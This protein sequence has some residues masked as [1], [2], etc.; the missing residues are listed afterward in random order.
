MKSLGVVRFAAGL[1]ILFASVR[2]LMAQIIVSV[3]EFGHGFVN[4]NPIPVQS[5]GSLG[6]Q[7]TL[8]YVVMPGT[9]TIHEG[10]LSGPISDL[11]LFTNTFLFF[12]SSS[13]G[14]VDSLADVASFIT[15]AG[16]TADIVEQGSGG[17]SFALYTP[18]SGQPGFNT[19]SSLG[20]NY[21][22]I[23]D[24]PEPSA[25]LL[26]MLGGG[27]LLVRRARRAKAIPSYGA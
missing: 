7:Y 6:L 2:V 13:S 9:V 3:D 12:E 11:I 21:T 24:I 23:S 5:A 15:T 4:T 1:V 22:F 16:P 27:L 26:T 10:S 20:P 18:V 19:S 14:G 17:N 8:P 25:C